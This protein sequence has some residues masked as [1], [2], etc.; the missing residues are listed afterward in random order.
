[1]A[2]VLYYS[3]Q[4]RY[5]K[6]LCQQLAA[7]PQVNQQFRYIDVASIPQNGQLPSAV[8]TLVSQGRAYVGPDAFK[9]VQLQV[10]ATAGPQCYDVCDPCGGM[11]FS[12][13]GDSGSTHR[14]QPFCHL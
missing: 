9:W 8:P 14:T 3:L 1:M 6:A 13:I 12:D 2:H 7:L 11:Q 10:Q 5:S 4:C